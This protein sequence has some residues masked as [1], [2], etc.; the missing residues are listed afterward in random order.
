[1]QVSIEYMM[2][3]ISRVFM[4]TTFYDRETFVDRRRHFKYVCF[5]NAHERRPYDE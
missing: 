1:M 5:L 3:S 4:L 2:I